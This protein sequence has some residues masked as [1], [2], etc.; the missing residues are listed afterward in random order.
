MNNINCHFI[1]LPIW[2]KRFARRSEFSKEKVAFFQYWLRL[3][4]WTTQMYPILT[5]NQT[6][7]CRVFFINF[8]LL[9]SSRRNFKQKNLHQTH[10]R[11]RIVTSIE[12]PALKSKLTN[13]VSISE[14]QNQYYSKS[15]YWKKTHR[16]GNYLYI[17]RTAQL[18]GAVF[19]QIHKYMSI[20]SD[21][22]NIGMWMNMKSISPLR[23]AKCKI[24]DYCHYMCAF[25]CEPH[26]NMFYWVFTMHIFSTDCVQRSI[27]I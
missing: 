7:Q 17:V 23:R 26:S 10:E 15:W 11:K 1:L 4:T 24:V 8:L 12:Q 13:W 21:L 25:E 9:I 20:Y 27:A 5:L 18:L 14:L 19:F 16:N 2:Y 6:F 3:N 22:Y